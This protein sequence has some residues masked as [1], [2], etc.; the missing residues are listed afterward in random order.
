MPV[1]ISAGDP[2]G[3]PPAQSALHAL[4]GER[5]RA[6][7]LRAGLVQ[8]AVAA[9]CGIQQSH[10]SQLE[11]GK[12][13]W[14]LEHVVAAGRFLGVPVAELLGETPPEQLEAEDTLT[15]PRWSDIERELRRAQRRGDSAT[16]V[17]VAALLKGFQAAKRDGEL[18]D[19][20]VELVDDPAPAP[21]PPPDTTPRRAPRAK[22]A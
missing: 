19:V 3:V 10:F 18:D 1:E 17:A 22:K 12:K 7:R 14:S 6:A 13:P 20:D 15:G 21:P 4:I 9:A 8:A 2:A 11:S 16:L 5:V